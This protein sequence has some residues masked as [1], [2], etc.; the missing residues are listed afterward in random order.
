[1][2]SLLSKFE[3]L[4]GYSRLDVESAS[5]LPSAALILIFATVSDGQ[6]HPQRSDAAAT[7]ASNLNT[8][9][10]AL[11]SLGQVH[12]SAREHLDSL[13]IIQQK[14]KAIHKQHQGR[15]RTERTPDQ[16]FAGRT[17]KRNKYLC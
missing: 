10:R 7:L 2:A 4:F 15:K 8:L 6:P 14:W 9:F 3:K 11:D 5:L 1:M 12:V 16:G 17:A 13:L